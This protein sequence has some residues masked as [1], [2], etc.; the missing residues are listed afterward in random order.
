M[1]LAVIR[2]IGTDIKMTITKVELK[3]V[4]ALILLVLGIG[5]IIDYFKVKMSATGIESAI[6]GVILILITLYMYKHK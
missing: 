5:L 1:V 3:Y 6:L 4:G 2:S